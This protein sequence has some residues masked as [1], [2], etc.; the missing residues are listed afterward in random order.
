MKP[1]TDRVKMFIL[2]DCVKNLCTLPN[3]HPGYA[4][5]HAQLMVWVESLPDPNEIPVNE[6]DKTLAPYFAT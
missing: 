3:N 6:C 4:E 1:L 5:A 2:Q